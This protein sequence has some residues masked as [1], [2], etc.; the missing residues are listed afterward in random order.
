MARDHMAAGMDASGFM[1]VIP[2]P[3]T[4]IFNLALREGYLPQDYNIDKMHW[5]RAN[6]INTT[7]P[8]AELERIQQKAWEEMNSGWYKEQKLALVVR[9]E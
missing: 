4:P 2:L 8:P 5:Q 7:V 9:V 6:M 1:I 3:G